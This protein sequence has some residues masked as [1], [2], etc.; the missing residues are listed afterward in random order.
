MTAMREKK[1]NSFLFR[2]LSYWCGSQ[3]PRPAHVLQHTR[4]AFHPMLTCLSSTVLGD[5]PPEAV[6]AFGKLVSMTL[7]DVTERGADVDPLLR[8]KLTDIADDIVVVARDAK[9]RR[10]MKAAEEAG[11]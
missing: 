6:D 1:T 11:G 10:E 9:E 5:K 7:K 3:S 2:R 8:Y 4:N